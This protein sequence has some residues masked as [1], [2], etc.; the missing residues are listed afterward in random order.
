MKS[1]FLL[2]ILFLLFALSGCTPTYDYTI[3]KP[4]AYFDHPSKENLRKILRRKVG[5]DYVWAEEGPHE[6]DCSGLVYYSYGTM[7]AYLPRV[8]S[9]Q[10]KAGRYVSRNNLQYGDLI[11]FDTT[12]RRSGKITHVGI[13]IGDGKFEHAANE[14][15]GVIITPL[16][17]KYY[18]RRIVTCRRILP[19]EK[20]GIT[21]MPSGTFTP[22]TNISIADSENVE[23]VCKKCYEV[24]EKATDTVGSYYIQVGI[25]SH[26][27]KQA[28]LEH[29]RV[30]GYG[31]KIQ[32]AD[33]HGIKMTQVLVG[34]FR[35]ESKAKEVL[36][37]TQA[38]FNPGA[39]IVKQ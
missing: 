8:A 36:P 23:T 24:T 39:F 14:R 28:F 31:Y 11:F 1:Y 13:Y 22:Q 37:D 30:S 25:F 34:P 12:S 7:N 4:R 17:H 5:D 3:H 38:L 16:D 9:E 19:D 35:S 2:L 10:A 26:A 29:L 20:S 33:R 6:F 32:T 18:G 27:P 21:T 15:Q